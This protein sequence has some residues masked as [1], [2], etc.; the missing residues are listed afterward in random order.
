MPSGGTVGV[1]GMAVGSG[2]LAGGGLV[3]C[4]CC[5]VAPASGDV[6]SPTTCWGAGDASLQADESAASKTRI[7]S[8]RMVFADRLRISDFLY[9]G[10]L[11]V[12]I[13]KGFSPLHN[14]SGHFFIASLRYYHLHSVSALQAGRKERLYRVS[15]QPA[16]YR[17]AALAF[18]PHGQA[19]PAVGQVFQLQPAQAGR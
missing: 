5:K 18:H 13:R 11:F 7:T 17:A 9:S 14:G 15:V 12:I 16:G 6:A 10:L 3:G 8:N 1:G 19:R 2:L 4:A